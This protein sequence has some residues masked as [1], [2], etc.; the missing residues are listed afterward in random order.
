VFDKIDSVN[1]QVLGFNPVGALQNV[2]VWRRYIF[3]LT[4]TSALCWMVLGWESTWNQ[5]FTYV[6]SVPW[7][8]MGQTSFIE[9]HNQASTFYGLG[10]HLSTPFIYGVCFLLLS[11]HLEK[12]RIVRSMNFFFS[13]ALSVFSVGVYEIIYN[14]LYSNLQNQPWTFTFAGKQGLNLAVFTFFIV[15][16]CVALVYLYS[17][18]F[19]LNFSRVTLLLLV[20]SVV[21]YGCWVFF[22]FPIDSFTVQT[23]AGPWTNTALFPQ[24]MYA[25]NLDPMAGCSAAIGTPYFVENNLLHLVNVLNKLFVSLTVL[26]FVMV[27]KRGVMVEA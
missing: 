21:T 18:K 14:V 16:G 12:H 19:K 3:V 20:L 4:V 8:L 23:T 7:L 17:L 5:A 26:S 22:P 25:V 15:V 10:Q 2:R 9:V 11:L 27:T 24:T 1:C 13:T 6:K